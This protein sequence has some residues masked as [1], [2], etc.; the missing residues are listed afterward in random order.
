MENVLDVNNFSH[1]YKV[2]KFDVIEPLARHKHASL[3]VSDLEWQASG[4]P[5]VR[6]SRILVE[7]HRPVQDKISVNIFGF[8]M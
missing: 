1:L 4:L 2:K 8:L 3:A 6:V 5:R 7:R